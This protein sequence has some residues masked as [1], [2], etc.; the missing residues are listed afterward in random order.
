MYIYANTAAYSPNTLNNGFP[1]QATM[2]QGK[3]FFT[4]PSRG[5]NGNLVRKKSPTFE[6]Y[7]SQP[8]LFFNSLLPQEQQF[9]I[10]AIRFETSHLKSDTVKKNVL[11]NLNK[12]DNDIAAQVA[13]VLDLPA[14]APDSKY[15]HNNKTTGVSV[16]EKPLLS[17]KG[18]KV[19]YLA[20][21][22]TAASATDIKASL[23]QAGVQL[24]TVAEGLG[25]GIDKTY[26]AADATDFDGVI[27]ASG[28][29]SIFSP[30]ATASTLY[31][32][33]RPLQ[34]LLDSYHYGKPVGF[35]GDGQAA[36]QAANIPDGP[37]VYVQSSDKTTKR[38][39]LNGT[40]STS[41]IAASFK[42][43]LKTFKF[44][45][46]FPVQSVSS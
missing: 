16:F 14:P 43:G 24:M 26:S 1:K 39:S 8:R 21:K 30:N 34:I 27:V 17:L 18:L 32:A 13:Q 36:I 5:A 19:G 11:T 3:G 7:Y 46:R 23:A 12:I 15:Y 6:D 22:A 31:P 4:T 35:I 45:D 29:S 40:E 10:N 9:L 20:T 28:T 37:G 41:D 44:L 38:S 25:Q 33:G 2:Q 42:E